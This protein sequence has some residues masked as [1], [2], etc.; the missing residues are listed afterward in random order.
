MKRAGWS[1]GATQK[2]ELSAKKTP[3]WGI[4]IQFISVRMDTLEGR[5]LLD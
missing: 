1:E 3:E 5:P 2:E 4:W